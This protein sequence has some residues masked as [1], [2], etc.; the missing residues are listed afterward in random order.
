MMLF[1][2]FLLCRL[3][4]TCMLFVKELVIRSSLI[5][6]LKK[7]EGNTVY[8]DIGFWSLGLAIGVFV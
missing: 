4:L 5:I 3:L 1:H 2:R 6:R 7:P 8:D